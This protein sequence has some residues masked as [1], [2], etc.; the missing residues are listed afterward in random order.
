MPPLGE[1]PAALVQIFFYQS[2]FLPFSYWSFY[3][4]D[5]PSI[6]TFNYLKRGFSKQPTDHYYRTMALALRHSGWE[7]NPGQGSC[8]GDKNEVRARGGD[9]QIKTRLWAR[10][11]DTVL[12]LY[13]QPG[14]GPF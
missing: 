11:S 5:N 13:C 6:S 10:V 2:A 12:V 7:N 4:E 9:A 8:Y 3:A 1:I 14:I